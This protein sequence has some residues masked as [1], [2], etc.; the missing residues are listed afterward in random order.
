M[1][2]QKIPEKIEDPKDSALSKKP[3]FMNIVYN[4]VSSVLGG[5]GGFN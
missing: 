2:T 5:F 1:N 3:S 4:G